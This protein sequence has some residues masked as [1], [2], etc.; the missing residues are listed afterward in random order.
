MFFNVGINWTDVCTGNNDEDIVQ[1]NTPF[2][3]TTALKG[4]ISSLDGLVEICHD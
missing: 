3:D 2:G 4:T 1:N